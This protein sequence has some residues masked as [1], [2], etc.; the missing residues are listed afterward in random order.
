MKDDT[1]GDM[2]PLPEFLRRT[3]VGEGHSPLGASAAHRWFACPGS[4]RLE[5]ACSDESSRE[6]REGT[7]AHDVVAE[8]FRRDEEAWEH[9]GRTVTVEGDEF[10]VDEDMVEAVDLMLRVV[11]ED[12]NEVADDVLQVYD[13][14]HGVGIGV[15][16]EENPQLLYCAAGALHHLEELRKDMPAFRL[17]VEVLFDLSDLHPGLWGTADV[18][19]VPKAPPETVE[20]VVV[21]PRHAHPDGPVRR[22]RL[23]VDELG[24]WVE[25]TLLPRARAT[26]DPEAPLRPG[27]HCRFCSAR[28]SCP[29][30][31][32]QFA[33]LTANAEERTK[34]VPEME[35]YELGDLLERA[36]PLKFLL[37]AAEDEAFK[38]LVAGREVPGQKLVRKKSARVWSEGSEDE[39]VEKLGDKAYCRTLVSPA[40]A[41]K[42]R[43][44]EELVK[45]L[46][47]T[48]EAD[49]TL[50]SANDRRPA[51]PGRVV[52]DEMFAGVDK[53]GGEG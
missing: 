3:T 37:R 50:A 35:D 51:V 6:A 31:S 45:R 26:V 2:P 38:R 36:A 33:E 13:Y 14:K 22:W 7:A 49:V 15:E 27:D 24:E 21:Q 12:A 4:P 9:A 44:G 41:E 43:G 39:V 34:A 10:A 20:I 40:Q 19:R 42:L 1:P 47:H 16:V 11:R 23:S 53:D 46:A 17:A 8:C 32:E 5:A 25:A 30:L 28:L 18:V 48:P 52:A 29:A